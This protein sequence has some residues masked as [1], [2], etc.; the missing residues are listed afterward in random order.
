MT[1]TSETS[2]TSETSG[3]TTHPAARG[4]RTRRVMPVLRHCGCP[5]VVR[6]SGGGFAAHKLQRMSLAGLHLSP[7]RPGPVV[8]ARAAWATRQAVPVVAGAPEARAQDG[9]PD[10]WAFEVR[11]A[12][13]SERAWG[14]A[15]LAILV[16]VV[17]AAL[18]ATSMI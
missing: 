15:S 17:L 4:V 11:A 8:A 13:S 12:R 2:E 5:V 16:A 9:A 1:T 7:V 18:R 10:A 6:A 14:L 3:A